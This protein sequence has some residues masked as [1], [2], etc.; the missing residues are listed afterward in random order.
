MPPVLVSDAWKTVTVELL[1]PQPPLTFNRINLKA[2]SVSLDGDRPVGVRIGD[3][4][5]ARIAWEVMPG[6]DNSRR[7]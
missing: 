7:P 6:Q 5:I 4:R 2:D 1:P 3:I